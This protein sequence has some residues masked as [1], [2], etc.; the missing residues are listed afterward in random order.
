MPGAERLAQDAVLG[1]DARERERHD[2]DRGRDEEQDALEGEGGAEMEGHDA[3]AHRMADERERAVRLQT[4]ALEEIEPDAVAAAEGP[5]APRREEGTREREPEPGQLCAG[6]EV[7]RRHEGREPGD[8][9]VDEHERHPDERRVVLD[10]PRRLRAQEM[11][12]LA[13]DDPE[14]CRGQEDDVRRE[15]HGDA[16]R[17]VIHVV[18][19]GAVESAVET[20]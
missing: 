10:P 2:D 14:G 6:R 9:R 4:M 20:P 18:I 15:Q 3:E 16:E 1:G 13:A 11:S 8:L 12:A 19:V 7:R 5:H 17:A